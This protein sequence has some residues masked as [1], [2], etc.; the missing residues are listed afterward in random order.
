MKETIKQL[1][2]CIKD[3]FLILIHENH[4]VCDKFPEGTDKTTILYNMNWIKSNLNYYIKFGNPAFTEGPEV[5]C[6]EEE[7]K[8][9]IDSLR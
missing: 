1:G 2:Y 9:F 7:L 5:S 6:S 3:N 8:T 4:Y